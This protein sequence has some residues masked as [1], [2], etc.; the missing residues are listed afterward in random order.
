M[1]AYDYECQTCGSVV[2][3]IHSIKLDAYKNFICP[4][5]ESD[6]PCKR[7]ISFN[8]SG[9]FILKGD[10]WTIK[11]SGFGKRG[12]LGKHQ[13]KIRGIGTPVDAPSYKPEADMQFQKWVDS[14]GLEGIKPTLEFDAKAKPKTGEQYLEKGKS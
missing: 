4:V 10:G 11:R 13:D 14:G 3:I 9:G 6:Q 2:E 8:C 5:C 12:Y 1:P 7:L